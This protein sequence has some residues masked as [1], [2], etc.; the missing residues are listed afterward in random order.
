LH[1]NKTPACA[2]GFIGKE[3]FLSRPADRCDRFIATG[4]FHLPEVSSAFQKINHLSSK[5]NT[6]RPPA[7]SK[8]SIGR[9]RKPLLL[10]DI[11]VRA[12][13]VRSDFVSQQ[14]A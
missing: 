8:L 13:F 11:V 10:R 12:D 14:V 3:L 5:S 2:A 9:G 1:K 4:K 6:R 7:V